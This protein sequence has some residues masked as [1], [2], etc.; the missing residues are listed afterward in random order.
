MRFLGWLTFVLSL[1]GVVL[2]VGFYCG[3]ALR[4]GDEL[5]WQE[6]I[7]FYVLCACILVVV[8]MEL[9]AMRLGGLSRVTLPGLTAWHL[10]GLILLGISALIGLIAWELFRSGAF[11]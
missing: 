8:V 11:R 9:I 2:P 6:G 5:W 1:T 7:G 10:S 3:M 4:F